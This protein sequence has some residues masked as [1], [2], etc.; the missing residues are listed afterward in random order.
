MSAAFIQFLERVAPEQASLVVQG[1]GDTALKSVL[2]TL[3]EALPEEHV[4]QFERLLESGTSSEVEAFLRLHIPNLDEVL[5]HSLEGL[6]SD[7]DQFLAD[8][9]E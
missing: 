7:L 8:I 9:G 4:P 2:V 1:L 6:R 3:I 5:E